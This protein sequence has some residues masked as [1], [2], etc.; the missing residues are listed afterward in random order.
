MSFTIKNKQTSP[1]PIDPIKQLIKT[2]THTIAKQKKE[3]Q[4]K[5]INDF[6]KQYR[7]RNNKK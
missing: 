3:Q 5:I 1:I 2:I 7:S 4:K 6:S